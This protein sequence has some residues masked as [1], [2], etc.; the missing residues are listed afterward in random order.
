ME[1]E[2]FIYIRKTISLWYTIALVFIFISF[3]EKPCPINHLRKCLYVPVLQN[4][5]RKKAHLG[6]V[7]IYAGSD[8][9][10]CSSQKDQIVFCVNQTARQWK[11]EKITLYNPNM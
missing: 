6:W 5:Q 2:Y 10:H 1:A 4:A 9:T 11:V 3:K 7:R 8:P